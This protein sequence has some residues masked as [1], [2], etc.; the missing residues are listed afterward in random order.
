M[1]WNSPI[2]Q[3]FG[4]TSEELDSPYNGYTHFNK[5]LDFAA[6]E[7]TQVPANVRGQVIKI[8]TN[9][10]ASDG[11]GL[12]VHIRDNKGN[13]H[14]YSHLSAI[15]PQL[16][17]GTNVAIGMPIGNVGSTGKSTGPHLSYDVSNK[18][19]EFFD[20]SGFVDTRIRLRPVEQI[21]QEQTYPN[22][23]Q[24]GK[25][26]V[27]Y[28]AGVTTRT[29]GGHQP[30]ISSLV[31]GKKPKPTS[32]IIQVKTNPREQAVHDIGSFVKKIKGA[33]SLGNTPDFGGKITFSRP[34]GL[35][36]YSKMLEGKDFET[37]Y[38]ELLQQELDLYDQLEALG[39][40][41]ISYDE[42]GQPFPISPEAQRIVAELNS[43]TM[44]RQRLENA[45]EQ[46]LLATGVDAAKTY[47]ETEQN[48]QDS[49]VK[50]NQDYF[51]RV[52]ALA[53]LGNYGSEA[54]QGASDTYN[55]AQKF[56]AEL[57]R[58]QETGEISPIIPPRVVRIGKPTI[59]PTQYAGQ[60]QASIPS[61][62]PSFYNIPDNAYDAYNAEVTKR[63]T[64]GGILRRPGQTQPNILED[65]P[66][67]MW[68]N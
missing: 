21:N 66:S 55:N 31:T 34:S 42:K 13:V 10:N 38:W 36:V 7:G 64:I 30:P 3:G 65:V 27:P 20:P 17:L 15:N 29:L 14:R 2:I 41:D 48:K 40:D 32:G 46:G 49:A 52:E 25:T 19:N 18:D 26:P 11:W 54:A 44:A 12:S 67:W 53:K 60:I 6:P 22:Q 8:E 37:A 58:G 4:P 43:I 5:G 39:P 28:R 35:G 59:D 57:W 47:L 9:P 68:G 61:Q 16:K 56:N 23:I 63:R 1:V 45:R 33:V 51:G 50:A 24:Q 62:V